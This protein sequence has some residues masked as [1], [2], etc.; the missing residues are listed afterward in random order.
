MGEAIF[1]GLNALG[2]TLCATPALHAFRRQHPGDT[3]VCVVQSAPFCHV[4]DDN[5]DIDVL[6]YSEQ[7]YFKGIPEETADWIRSLPIDLA[8][9][10]T[11]YRLDMRFAC[12]TIDAFHRHI[13]YRFAEL[14]GVE[15]ESPRPFVYLDALH[16]RA[17]STL[18]SRPFIVFST[19][20]VSN[21]EREDKRGRKKDWPLDRWAELAN[22][23]LAE[24][25][26]DIAVIGAERD[27]RL[28]ISGVRMLYGLPIRVV[29]AL[30]ERAAC[31][32][33]LESGIGH[34]AYAVDA[35]T[36]VIYSNMMP[37]EWARP[38]ELSRFRI[39]YGDP[40]ETSVDDVFEAVQTLTAT[41]AV[42][43]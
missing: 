17:A 30:L 42:T 15:I 9:G 2:D 5:P 6:I 41:C 8:G 13:S 25:E 43:R 4:L 34:L 27:P 23:I 7:L 21:P 38:A 11:L 37:P 39:L 24:G 20:S 26:F 40:Y 22:R 29:A 32:V 12:S 14:V 36:V 18:V 33:T 19:N 1:L 16:R 35:R 31:V 28:P 10:A 3:M